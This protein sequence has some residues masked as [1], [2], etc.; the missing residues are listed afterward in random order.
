[1]TFGFGRGRPAYPGLKGTLLVDATRGVARVRAWPKKRGPSQSSQV[2][3]QNQRFKEAQYYAKRAPGVLQNMAIKATLN[4]GLYPRDLLTK[5]MLKGIFDLELPDG[6]LVQHGRRELFPVTFQGFETRLT[7]GVGIPSAT[8][9]TVDWPTPI[10]DTAGFFDAGQPDRITVPE[11][12]TVMSISAGYRIASQYSGSQLIEITCLTDVVE[13]HASVAL[14]G[15]R[16]LVVTTGPMAV[17][18]GEQIGPRFYF[19]VGKTLLPTATFFSG[20]ILGAEP[21]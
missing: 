9:K 19:T 8:L 2:Q 3:I 12:V 18:A 20:Q 5:F 4:T 1:M 7:S 14:S 10:L 21:V 15:A 11:G 13:D 16:D 6:T 17:V